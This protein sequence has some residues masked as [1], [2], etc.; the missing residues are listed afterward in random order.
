MV[1]TDK[2]KATDAALRETFNTMDAER[3]QE[4]REAYH[5]ATEGL[6]TLAEALESADAGSLK[7]PVLS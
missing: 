3:A 1:N 6:M 4:I 7:A 5:K 2:H